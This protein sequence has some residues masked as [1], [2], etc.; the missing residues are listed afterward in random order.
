MH[1]SGRAKRRLAGIGKIEK[2]RALLRQRHAIAAGELHEEIM[3][4]LAVD[5]RRTA[6]GGL[7]AAE[8]Q[9]IAALAHERI[10]RQH[11]A[12]AQRARPQRPLAHRHAHA[13]AEPFAGTARAALMVVD[14]V[15]DAMEHPH[16]IA[17][18]E[19][20][21]LVGR[22]IRLPAR[23]RRL[24]RHE[25]GSVHALHRPHR[26]DLVAHIHAR[27]RI[28]VHATHGIGRL[29]GLIGLLRP[30]GERRQ[31]DDRRQQCPTRCAAARDYHRRHHSS[32]PITLPA[33]PPEAMYTEAGY[34]CRA[35]GV[36]P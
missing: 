26:V 34:S 24:A 23:S 32:L 19:L 3:R 30:R 16:P 18:H 27:H 10:E 36:S 35:G 13:V 22:G 11:R 33:S 17:G 5:Q 4:M 7:A 9:R 29:L 6:V 20:R 14:A 28:H 1:E 15:D 25:I 2:D 8:Q 31:G 12:Q 21:A